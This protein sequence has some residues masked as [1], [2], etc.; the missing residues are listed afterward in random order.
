[1]KEIIEIKAAID[2]QQ[3]D[4]ESISGINSLIISV[5]LVDTLAGFYSGYESMVHRKV[6]RVE[7]C[8]W[9]SCYQHL[10][11]LVLSSRRV[12]S[13]VSGQVPV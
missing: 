5:C 7:L 2:I 8:M 11:S 12:I 4:I 6:Y 10:V 3:K 1:M 9:Q 13:R